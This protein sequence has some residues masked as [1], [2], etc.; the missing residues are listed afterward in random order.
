MIT[1]PPEA[2]RFV[3]SSAV[4][5]MFLDSLEVLDDLMEYTTYD[6]EKRLELEAFDAAKFRWL[7][8]FT[9]EKMEYTKFYVV[10]FGLAQAG[11]AE[12]TLQNYLPK[13]EWEYWNSLQVSS[14]VGWN[15]I[16]MRGF[17]KGLTTITKRYSTVRRTNPSLGGGVVL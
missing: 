3:C 14:W 4:Q 10:Q 15:P 9:A 6:L 11:C 17:I 2:Q 12:L 1:L 16:D 5:T 13:V 7:L 8:Y